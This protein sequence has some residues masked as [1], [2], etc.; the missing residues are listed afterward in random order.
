MKR[1]ANVEKECLVSIK[2]LVFF[3]T[4]KMNVVELP[5]H[6]KLC[7]ISYVHINK[8]KSCVKERYDCLCGHYRGLCRFSKVGIIDEY[9]RA[10]IL[11]I[12]FY[13][14]YHIKKEF[15]DI[16]EML[17]HDEAKEFYKLL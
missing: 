9:F 14:M 5:R 13:S 6:L 4:S 3:V 1:I 15:D 8:L 12:Y 2:S 17:D 7:M 11:Y 10:V 16:A